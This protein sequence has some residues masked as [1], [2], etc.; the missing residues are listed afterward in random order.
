[1]SQTSLNQGTQPAAVNGVNGPSIP[2]VAALTCSPFS[3][4]P[5]WT[6]PGISVN[7]LQSTGNYN[8]VNYFPDHLNDYGCST[9]GQFCSPKGVNY[10]DPYYGGRGPQ[11]VSYNFSMQRMINK[12]AVLTIAYSGSQ[13]HFLPHGSGRGYAT[14]TVSPDYGQQYKGALN[15]SLTGNFNCGAT[16]ITTCATF[17]GTGA[18][19]FSS[20]TAF[21][22]FG[23]LTDLWGETGNA[24]YNSLQVSVIQRPWHNLSGLINYTRAKELDDTGN[25]R[26][27]YPI[28]P[29]DGNFS[30]TY[31]ANQIDRSLGTSN[32]TNAF[33]LTWVYSFPIG[34]GQA[35]F[36]TNR[37]AGLIGGGWQLSGI[38]KYRDGYPLQ[39]TTSG[40]CDANA[41]AGQ[42]TC[43]P[44]YTPG[45]DKRKVRING[46]W[47]RGPG[48]GAASLT[49]I[50]YINSAAFQ[51]PD[52]S[53]TS[54]TATCGNSNSPTA[55]WKIGNIA[56]SAPD[57]L[58]GPGWWD[59]D[60]GLR[61]TFNVR[62]TATLHLTFQ[63]EADVTNTTNSTFFNIASTAWNGSTFGTVSGQ[64]KS[65]LPR[66]WQFAG[67]FRF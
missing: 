37:I 2:C 5:P 54:N 4:I 28:G 50:Q 55:T 65:I 21:P 29:Q 26:S 34:R 42:G 61:R 7:P 6:V 56:R 52:S 10:A 13:T 62:E 44:D 18:T 58:H 59:V 15:A 9:N 60:M 47:G 3:A 39:I 1:V 46:R 67:R 33:N 16:D 30:R 41:L 48:A 38:Y 45:F 64:N 24:A 36:A 40:G 23:T 66:D 57:G 12:K 27:Q 53:P 22:Q 20:L 31:S 8:F 43:M 25:H 35:F 14:N 32:Q 11:F 19:L 17:G 49:Q 63:F 51:C